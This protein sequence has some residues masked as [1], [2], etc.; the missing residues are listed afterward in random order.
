[1]ETE[2]QQ[3]AVWGI[4]MAPPGGDVQRRH[5]VDLAEDL[6]RQGYVA[7]GWPDIGDLSTLPDDRSA[8]R[9]QFVRRYGESV[10][11]SASG[12]AA[13]MLYRFVHI[14]HLGDIIVSL[15]PL[16]RIVRVGHISGAYQYLPGLLEEYPNVRTVEWKAEVPRQD[17]G[18]Q[19]QLSLRARRSLF[20]ILAGE[21][22]FRALAMP[23]DT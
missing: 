7:I 21:A 19:A 16:G 18:E 9:E 22:E 13:G 8:F 6:Q 15:S 3:R 10:S 17:L 1:M 12:A 4:H 14:L 23:R 2:Q 11:A 20:R 5:L